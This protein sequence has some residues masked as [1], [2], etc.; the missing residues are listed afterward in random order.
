MLQ[1]EEVLTSSPE[2]KSNQSWCRKGWGE[3]GLLLPGK[4]K[5]GR[6]TIRFSQSN[7]AASKEVE[8]FNK[9]AGIGKQKGLNFREESSTQMPPRNGSKALAGLCR[10]L[11]FTTPKVFHEHSGETS[12]TGSLSLGILNEKWVVDVPNV[13]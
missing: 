2:E 3:F 9:S 5:M 11:G 13:T 6:N 7:P 4:R 12:A 10:G 1:F 8:E